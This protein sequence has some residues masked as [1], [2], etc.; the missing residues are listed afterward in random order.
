MSNIFN[1]IPNDLSEE[2]FE[3]LAGSGDVTIKRIVSKG[4]KSADDFWYDQAQNEWVM[5][6]RGQARLEFEHGGIAE[7]SQG[8]YCDIPAGQKH[9]VAWT[10]EDS[11]TIWLAVFY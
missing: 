2:V 6:L 10:Q 5:L 8:D 3:K 9:R 7:L 4:H 11:E 1:N